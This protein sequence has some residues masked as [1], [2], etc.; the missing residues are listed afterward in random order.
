MEKRSRKAVGILTGLLLALSLLLAACKSPASGGQNTDS[1]SDRETDRTK[2]TSST[3]TD[4]QP[5]KPTDSAFRLLSWNIHGYEEGNTQHDRDVVAALNKLA[6]DIIVLNESSDLL[7]QEHPE[8]ADTYGWADTVFGGKYATGNSILYRKDRFE[9]VSVYTYC[10]T[11]TPAKYTK[12]EGSH[13]YRF[14][15]FAELR[16]KT[17][18]KALTVIGT[19]LENNSGN[20]EV[21]PTRN[22]ARVLQA[23]HLLRLIRTEVPAG[24]PVVLMGDLNG[25]RNSAPEE[26]RLGG[27]TEL[28]ASGQLQDIRDIAADSDWSG[29]WAG[30]DFSFDYILATPGAFTCSAFSVKREPEIYN[31]SDH[32]PILAAVRFSGS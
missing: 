30:A 4:T 23:G 17:T 8:L 29:S 21:F 32:N 14:A 31:P 6:A 7:R 24:M 26:Y 13:H 3:M 27:I 5:T 10:L 12:V 28:L 22:Q 1:G 25:I 2:E 16:D 20:S 9:A 19:H 11:D 18:G 15:T